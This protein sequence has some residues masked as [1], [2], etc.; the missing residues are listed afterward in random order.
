MILTQIYNKLDSKQRE[1]LLC[2]LLCGLIYGILTGVLTPLLPFLAAILIIAEVLFLIGKEKPK[3][4]ENIY[5]LTLR[6]K[7]EALLESAIITVNAAVVF[8][9][10]KNTDIMAILQGWYPA[11]ATGLFW[12]GVIVAAIAVIAIWIWLNS[13]KYAVKRK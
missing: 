12:I 4:G 9:F 6:H 13:R 8:R 7:C 2:G 10:L 1:A 3:K 11:I 5:L